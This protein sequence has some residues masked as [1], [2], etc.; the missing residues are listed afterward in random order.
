MKIHCHECL[1][2]H[3]VKKLIDKDTAFISEDGRY[4]CEECL[5]TYSQSNVKPN[6]GGES[7]GKDD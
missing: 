4:L 1:K 6:L 5:L 3:K 2:K 7:Y